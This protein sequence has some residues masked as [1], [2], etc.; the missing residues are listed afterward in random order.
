MLKVDS[1]CLL[2]CTG[3]PTL[4]FLR[5]CRLEAINGNGASCEAICKHVRPDW[6]NY[7]V[8]LRCRT[9]WTAIAWGWVIA[10]LVAVSLV[11]KRNPADRENW[12]EMATDCVTVLAT[13]FFAFFFCFCCYSFWYEREIS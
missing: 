9:I 3:R 4:M 6:P 2:F 7:G 10:S 11:A 8:A 13:F 12:F 5:D 1:E